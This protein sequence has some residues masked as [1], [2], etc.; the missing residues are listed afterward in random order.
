MLCFCVPS[1]P[2]T[3]SRFAFDCSCVARIPAARPAPEWRKWRQRGRA[4]A[5]AVAR[6][7]WRNQR[8]SCHS[9]HRLKA[10]TAGRC[11]CVSS[12]AQTESSFVFVRFCVSRS[13]APSPARTAAIPRDESFSF[14]RGV[15]CLVVS[16]LSDSLACCSRLPTDRRFFL[17]RLG[18]GRWPLR[19]IHYQPVAWGNPLKAG[20][21]VS[22][23][24]IRSSPSTPKGHFPELQQPGRFE[25][26]RCFTRPLF[27]SG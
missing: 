12:S 10:P 27:G 24:A 22:A 15:G 19:W 5:G 16:V 25:P 21:S 11:F 7:S 9:R 17:H 6:P 23:L 1:E 26:G 14:L 2:E 18:P 3:E 4:P 8:H 20:P 13:T